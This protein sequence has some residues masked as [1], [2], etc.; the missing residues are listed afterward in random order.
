MLGDRLVGEIADEGDAEDFALAGL[1]EQEDPGGGETKANSTGDDPG[2][3]DDVLE[4][5]FDY[6]VI[7]EPGDKEVKTLEGMETDSVVG[8]EAVH[9]ENVD[10]GDPAEE[11]NVTK[12]GGGLGVDTGKEVVGIFRLFFGG[13]RRADL[14]RCATAATERIFGLNFEATL[15]TKRHIFSPQGVFNSLYA[16]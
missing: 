11:G 7:D 13:R 1:E 3:G 9:A 16:F 12:D 5:A 15:A 4:D 10:R 6:P 8:S 2:A 14:L